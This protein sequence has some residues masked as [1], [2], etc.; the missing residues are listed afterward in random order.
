MSQTSHLLKAAM[1]L[2]QAL[3]KKVDEKLPEKL[4]GIVKTHAAIAV[5]SAFVPIPGADIAAAAVNIWAMYVRINKDLDLPFAENVIKSI[6]AGVAT[7]LAGAATAAVVIGSLAKFLP[8]IGTIGGAAIMATTIYAITI[9]SGIVYMKAVTK[10]LES[11]KV[12]EF[13]EE[14]LKSAT[15]EVLKDKENLKTIIKEGKEGYK[16]R[17][18][19]DGN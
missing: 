19:A 6:A 4:A 18:D 17:N 15:D 2:T 8:G 12:G 7:N 9:A 3:N 11:K 14:N 1:E 5:G 10:L 16:K 13:T